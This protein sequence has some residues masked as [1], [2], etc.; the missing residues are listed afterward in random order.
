VTPVEEC[1]NRF[2]D[3]GDDEDSD[4]HI[5][6]SKNMILSVVYM[7]GPSV[8]VVREQITC[9]SHIIEETFK[10]KYQYEFLCFVPKKHKTIIYELEN[11]ADALKA[12]RI[13]RADSVFEAFVWGCVKGRG[14]YVVDARQVVYEI[15]HISEA[16]KNQEG[17][18][19]V[20]QP[21]GLPSAFCIPISGAKDVLLNVFKRLHFLGYGAF[22]EMEFLC[23]MMERKIDF[24][25]REYGMSR[26]TF[27]VEIEFLVHL[28]MRQI[29]LYLYEIGKWKL[30]EK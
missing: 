16:C 8:S 6:A 30:P 7:C 4:V 13:F 9:L 2:L 12:I 1:L 26:I 21:E 22:F 27:S 11:L 19:R 17:F 10:S 24:V 15:D 3:R 14:R 28:L 5:D 25:K 20:L 23:E 29:M 18:I